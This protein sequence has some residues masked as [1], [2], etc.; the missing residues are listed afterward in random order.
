MELSAPG[1]GTLIYTN[2][3]GVT[4]RTSLGQVLGYDSSANAITF[5]FDGFDHILDNLGLHTIKVKLADARGLWSTYYPN[6]TFVSPGHPPG[7]YATRAYGISL[8]AWIESID[9]YGLCRIRFVKPMWTEGTPLSSINATTLDVYVAP[10]D[11]RYEDNPNFDL[12]KFN[13]TW[14]A[15]EFQGDTMLLELIFPHHPWI[16]TELNNPDDLVIVVRNT[17]ENLAADVPRANEIFTTWHTETHEEAKARREGRGRPRRLRATVNE[18]DATGQHFLPG[19]HLRTDLHEYFVERNATMR[20]PIPRQYQGGWSLKVLKTYTDSKAELLKVTIVV[21]FLGK[22]L[23]IGN[24]FHLLAAMVCSLQLAVHLPIM[25]YVFPTNVMVHLHGMIPIAMLDVLEN[26]EFYQDIFKSRAAGEETYDLR[27]QVKDLH[28]DQH[29]PW[30]NMGTISL[31]LWAW[32]IRVVLLYLFIWP[33]VHYAKLKHAHKAVAGNQ[34]YEGGRTA[35][36]DAY[37][38]TN[39]VAKSSTDAINPDGIRGVRSG[40][41]G[42][43]DRLKESGWIGGYQEPPQPEFGKPGGA[44]FANP[45]GAAAAS[46]PRGF[47]FAF[48]W[49]LKHT[50]P[51]RFS[52]KKTCLQAQADRFHSWRRSLFWGEFFFIFLLGHLECLLCATL[53]W[54]VPNA[55]FENTGWLG[56]T[57]VVLLAITCVAMPAALIYILTRDV[58]RY[59]LRHFA[60]RWG[61]LYSAVRTRN[62]PQMFYYFLFVMRRINYVLIVYLW[63]MPHP[64]YQLLSLELTNLGMLIYF[65]AFFPRASWQ[66]NFL[67]A[68]NEVQVTLCTWHLMVFSPWV[69]DY[70]TQYFMGWVFIILL[71]AITLINMVFIFLAIAREIRLLIIKYW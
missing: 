9:R 3:T 21:S 5:N 70:D 28:Y 13:L 43:W 39:A 12:T 51:R 10:A 33:F 48:G 37:R 57:S 6:A 20:H 18:G 58:R 4:N 26:L 63:M 67:E 36:P 64:I 50:R 49:K 60:I 47:T 19:V 59:R 32:V 62:K 56:T 24:S 65:A 34:R 42:A 1:L 7:Q 68:C 25:Q 16:S 27:E 52:A 35:I 69:P 46:K 41:G 15:L 2:E 14:K 38:A 29:N 30:L 61:A 45:V 23:S 22:V 44:T 55:S 40:K 31:A 66:L 71:S 53:W 8:T 11:D 17:A 54:D